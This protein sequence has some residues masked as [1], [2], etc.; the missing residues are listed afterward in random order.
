MATAEPRNILHR[1]PGKSNVLECGVCEDVFGLQGDKVPRLLLCGHTLCHDCLTRLPLHGRAIRCPFDRQMT[2]IGDSGVWGLRVQDLYGSSLLFP[3]RRLGCVGVKGDS[4]VWGLKKNFALL[5]LLERLQFGRESPG[6]LLCEVSMDTEK[7]TTIR[8]D[9]NEDHLATIYCTVCSTNLCAECA[10]STHNTRTL[11]KH[12]LTTIRCDENEDHL[13]TIY[14]TVCSTNLC[15]ECAQST[16]NTRT[17]AKHK[18]TTIRC[19]ENED[20]LATIYCTVCSTNLCAECAQSTHNTRTLAKHKLVPLHEKPREKPMCPLHQTH[21]IEFACLEES[22]LCNPLMCYVCKD[23][24]K[25]QGHK[26]TLIENDA[27]QV[28]MSIIDTLQHVRGFLDG[29]S[30]SARRLGNAIQQ[31]EGCSRTV[32]N[33]HGF[34]HTEQIHGTAEEARVRVRRYFQEL[35]ETLHRQENVALSVVDTHVREKLCSLKQQQEDMAVVVSQ[36]T[37]ICLECEKMLQQ[38]DHKV[39]LAKQEIRSL[40]D[41]VRKQQ[42]QFSDLPEQLHMDPGIPLTFTKDN[43]VHIGPK[44]EMRVVTLGLDESGKTAILFKL[45]QD[46]FMQT[47]PTIGFNVET[48]EY[49]NLKFTIW[50]VGGKPK[51]RPL[52]KH[53]YLNTQA[54]IFVVDSADCA[55]LDEAHVSVIFVVDSADCAWLDEAHVSVIFV[56]DSADCARLDEAYVAACLFVSVIFVADSADC[57]R[58]DETYDEL[59]KL[60][61]EKELR[62][63]VLLVF[64]NK[65]DLPNALPIEEITDRLSLH[66]QCYHRQTESTQAD[67]PNALPIEEITDRL[68]LHKQCCTYYHRQTEPTQADLPNALPIEEI[69]DRLS[70]HK[71]CCGRSWHIQACDART[72]MG[73]HDGLDWLSHQLVAAGVLDI[74]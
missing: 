13:A 9:E 5:E 43:R 62:E 37:T 53:Y 4:G 44:M 60:L 16:H 20:H 61:A 25:H 65:Q 2:E 54:V 26:H 39:L 36:V 73:L 74:S 72:G 7:E 12:N 3:H 14:C 64:A 31:M 30:D 57:A 19:D 38:D 63:A 49:K 45:K 55:R 32:E 34:T 8:C 42:Q 40:L 69:T 24:G 51:L 67:L 70:L 15:A 18:L 46:E 50:D 71:L 21:A 41:T 1:R 52:W 23:Y 48:V 28:R 29:V 27:E 11:A 58:L 59:S 47:I 56:V 17:L 10:Q 35:H 6:A 68:S 66:K 22:C 33:E